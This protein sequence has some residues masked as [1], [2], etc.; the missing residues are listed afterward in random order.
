MLCINKK[1]VHQKECFTLVTVITSTVIAS[2]PVIT[3]IV[4][5][6]IVTVI[7]SAV[8]VS[9]SVSVGVTVTVSIVASRVSVIVAAVIVSVRAAS[10]IIVSVITTSVIVAWR[11]CPSYVLIEWHCQKAKTE[12]KGTWLLAIVLARGRAAWFLAFRLFDNERTA[13]QVFAS[14]FLNGSVRVRAVGHL[15]KAKASAL[16]RVGVHDDL[17]FVDLMCAVELDGRVCVVQCCV[18]RAVGAKGR[19]EVIFF[20]RN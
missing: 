6:V 3:T 16:S 14:Q 15:H 8:I 11:R 19:R 5:T 9:V 4:S 1:V 10:A 12:E 7:S 18:Y 2:V 20:H 17:D 13:L